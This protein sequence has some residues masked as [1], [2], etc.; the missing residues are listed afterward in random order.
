[1]LAALALQACGG[2][3]GGNNAEMVI[4]KDQGPQLET[5]K[6][7]SPRAGGSGEFEF[8]RYAIDVTRD[9]PRACLTFSSTLNPATDYRPFLDLGQR[10][11][12]AL[13]TEGANLCLGGL[14]SATTVTSRSARACQRTMA[15]HWLSMKQSRSRSATVLPMSASR[16]MA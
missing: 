16:A 8:V 1:M 15:A 10:S 9:L 2:P 14:I 12:I 6:G 11:A 7:N 13:Q 5:R 4:G 3:A